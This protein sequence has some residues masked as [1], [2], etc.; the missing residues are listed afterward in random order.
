LVHI[1]LFSGV[2]EAYT[3]Q[4]RMKGRSAFG[5]RRS[6]ALQSV[7]CSAALHNKNRTIILII[8][9]SKVNPVFEEVPRLQNE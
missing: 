7:W 4:L 3:R 2:V 8:S 1:S 6:A 5:V 9:A